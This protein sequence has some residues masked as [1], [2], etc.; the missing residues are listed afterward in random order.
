MKDIFMQPKVVLFQ[1][2]SITDAGRSREGASIRVTAMRGS[3]WVRW[4][5]VNHTSIS[6]IIVE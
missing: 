3:L 2:D 4:D 5:T 1:G 6:F